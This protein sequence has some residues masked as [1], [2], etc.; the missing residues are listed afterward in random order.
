MSENGWT[1]GPWTVDGPPENRIVWSSPGDRVCFMAHS[2]GRD[3]DRDVATSNLIAAAPDMA[4][5][6]ED[7]LD[8]INCQDAYNKARAALAKA[9]RGGVMLWRCELCQGTGRLLQ[10]KQTAPW[11]LC[12]ACEGKG[13]NWLARQIDAAT[14]ELRNKPRCRRGPYWQ[15]DVPSPDDAA[16]A[17]Q[18]GETE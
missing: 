13:N 3:P 2:D 6:L 8:H 16:K 15:D 10:A 17:N 1:P 9:K 12:P 7:S 18:T 11:V 5:A 4:E 14:E